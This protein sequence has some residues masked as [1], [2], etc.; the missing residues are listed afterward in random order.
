MAAISF[1]RKLYLVKLK[2]SE[3][4]SFRQASARTGIPK[5]TIH[6][7]LGKFRD[8]IDSFNRAV[9]ENPSERL[10]RTVLILSMSGKCST[11][12]IGSILHGIWGV[13]ISHQTIMSILSLAADIA[14]RFNKQLDLSSISSALFDEVFQNRTP[15]LVFASPV[16]GLIKLEGSD[17]RSGESWGK[18]LED[19]KNLGLNPSS[20]V[21]DGGRG[22][23]RGIA[24]T[25]AKATVI[26]DLFH[27]LNK[28]SKAKKIMEGTCYRLLAKAYQYKDKQDFDLA[29]H[30][31]QS[32]EDAANL[33]MSF[34]DDLERFKCAC[35]LDN[36]EDFGSYIDSQSLAKLVVSLEGD[37]SEFLGK[38]S[39][40]RAINDAKN[41]LKNGGCEIIAYKE[42]IEWLVQDKF[43][44]QFK[45]LAL[46]FLC[47]LIEY[48][49][50]Y[51]RSHDSNVRRSYWATKVA[52]L[53]AQFRHYK[54]INQVEVDNAINLIWSIGQQT[55]KSNSLIESVNSVIRAYLSTYKSIPSWFC[56]LFTFYWNHRVFER[57]KRAKRSPMHLHVGNQTSS[58]VDLIIEEF[59]LQKLRS[60]IPVIPELAGKE[61]RKFV[62]RA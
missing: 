13:N 59:P 48:L 2:D 11:R 43:G 4:L 7:N 28:L 3:D 37:L 49:D 40:H 10:V 24:D 45:E 51:L 27:V 54:I 29:Q 61:R 22:L 44:S 33:F 41:Y 50:Q 5:S 20:V 30:Y 9:G 15:I 47:P 52:R 23:L 36:S 6:D 62:M 55:V 14:E 8:E 12:D 58:W 25:F 32:F 56:Q 35:Y 53:R 46:N 31:M 19:L 18:F 1:E 39:T 21:T 16:S 17:D 38:Y 26:R 34:E 42:K 57:G 60:K